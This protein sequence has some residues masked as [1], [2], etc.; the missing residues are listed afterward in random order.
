MRRLRARWLALFVMALAAS[1]AGA[2]STGAVVGLVT[3][4]AGRALPDV[5]VFVDDGAVTTLTDTLGRFALTGLAPERHVLGYRHGGYAPRS[6]ALDLST[7]TELL[8]VG[9]V[10]LRP[11]GEPTASL[12]GLVTEGESGRGL[13]GATVALNG[14]VVAVTDST[15]AFSAPSSEVLWGANELTVEHRAFSDRS[16][17]DRIWISHSD[18]TLDLVVALDV[19]PIALPGLDVPGRSTRLA[20]EGFYERRE[21]YRSATFMTREEIAERNPRR[22]EDLLRGALGG[23]GMSRT[24]RQ[25]NPSLG[26]AGSV[27]PAQSFGRAE[28]GAPCLPIFYM[29]GL[30]IGS[31]AGAP[32]STPTGVSQGDAVASQGS[33]IARALDQL[34]SPEEIEGIEIYE[35]ISRMPAEYAPVGSVC[36]VVL[37][38][39]R[40]GN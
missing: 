31:L 2:Q 17:S 28:E 8:D 13:A 26:P 12:S 35:S 40:L 25:T 32:V 37:I 29:N 22:T 19:V 38:W 11:G 27:T 34:V 7:A 21:Q 3:D 20:A 15:G 4:S 9:T 36:G 1:A 30:R 33:S 14:R 24:I 10:V 16:V 18:E 39:T 5:L 23:S 6:F